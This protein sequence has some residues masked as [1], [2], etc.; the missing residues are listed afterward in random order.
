M[1]PRQVEA[2]R[3]HHRKYVARKREEDTEGHAAQMRAAKKRYVDRLRAEDPQKL[4]EMN[5]RYQRDSQQKRLAANPEYHRTVLRRAYRRNSG[6]SPANLRKIEKAIKCALPPAL[7]RQV[8]EEV[9]AEI[10]LTFMEGR[11]RIDDVGKS[12]K[13]HLTAHYRQYDQHKV[14][15]L[16]ALRPG[17]ETAWIDSLDSE[18]EHF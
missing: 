4:I 1:T 7:P 15:S 16:D 8:R 11:I 17:T 13:A 5:R 14:L 6:I 18:A 10:Y 12:V 3:A 2:K 9:K